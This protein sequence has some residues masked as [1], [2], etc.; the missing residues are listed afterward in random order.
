[1]AETVELNYTLETSGKEVLDTTQV[2][3]GSS[4]NDRDL[5]HNAF[6]VS[7]TLDASSVPPVTKV[8]MES[9]TLGAGVKTVDLQAAP[10]S[11]GQTHDLTGLKLVAWHIIAR[12]ANTGNVTVKFGAVNGY[13]LYGATNER[14]LTPGEDDSGL[15]RAANTKPAVA[16]ADSEIDFSGTSG[17]L[18]D[19]IMYFG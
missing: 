19:Y 11:V 18:V 14:D 16:A 1:M 6:D 2:P 9:F 12:A 7:G 3:A 8:I 17:D 10:G 13:D 15:V 5:N 4:E